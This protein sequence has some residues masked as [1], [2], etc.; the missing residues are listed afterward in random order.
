MFTKKTGFYISAQ[1]FNYI[2][3]QG[4]NYI[5]P[6]NNYICAHNN[7]SLFIVLVLDFDSTISFPVAFL[8]TSKRDIVC[9]WSFITPVIG[10]PEVPPWSISLRLDEVKYA[11]FFLWLQS[12]QW[13]SFLQ[14]SSALSLTML[15]DWY[16]VTVV[17][18]PDD[19]SA[20][21]ISLFLYF[22]SLRTS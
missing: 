7:L 14:L 13:L 1:R 20:R 6:Q 11:G 8:S 9:S 3:A 19:L 16:S 21:R 12:F 17:Q 2:Y 10:L 5:S 18:P 15:S 22:M 4:F